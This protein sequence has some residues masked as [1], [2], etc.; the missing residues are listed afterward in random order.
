MNKVIASLAA[1]A[2]SASISGCASATDGSIPGVSATCQSAPE[3]DA[4]GKFE[5][6]GGYGTVPT[7]KF[8][9]PLTSTQIET[10]ILS[11]GDGLKFTG[12]QFVDLDFMAINGGTGE[13]LQ[14]TKFDGTDSAAQLVA[15]GGYPDFCT[16]LAGVRAGSRISVLFPAAFAHKSEGA[17]QSGIGKD[18]SI[19]YV[20]D[21]RSVYLP[22][23]VGANQPAATGFP[24]VVRAPNGTPGITQL[25]ED[26]PKDFK[27]AT[28]IKGDGETV[29]IGD[30]I[31]VHYSG[32]VWGGESFDSSWD[33]NQPA[34]FQLAESNLI[35]GFVKALDGQTVGSQV[36]AIIPPAE[37]YGDAQQQSIPANSTLIF[38]IDILGT[39][40][41]AL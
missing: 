3:G 6:T 27:L 18:D 10:R 25:K 36:I 23:A 15:S 4:L 8:D 32:F 16:A 13:T 7:F 31:V 20:I 11:S 17:P 37:G 19:L 26:A 22:Y 35:K 14:T 34:E 5:V 41:P 21:V 24:S 2:I 38:V 39:K 12:D 30:N 40:K 9:A 1:I 28:L 29:N 33:R